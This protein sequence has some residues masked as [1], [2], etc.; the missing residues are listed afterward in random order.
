MPFPTRNTTSISLP[1]SRRSPAAQGALSDITGESFRDDE[2][3]DFM[4]SER[5]IPPQLEMM[6][7]RER[8]AKLA[9][10]FGLDP[11]R[12][13][14]DIIKAAER[15]RQLSAELGTALKAGDVLPESKRNT[16]MLKNFS[17]YDEDINVMG[18]PNAMGIGGGYSYRGKDPYGNR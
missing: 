8:T 17:H 2:I 15:I 11:N 13:P 18:D 16:G 6:K 4:A 5:L 12:K 1:P 10:Q 9:E 7:L 14:L 3:D